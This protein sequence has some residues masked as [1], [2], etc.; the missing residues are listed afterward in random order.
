MLPHNLKGIRLPA[1]ERNLLKYRALEMVILLFYV[2]YLKSLVLDSIRATDRLRR[3]QNPRI[4]I[5]AKKAYEK[6]WAVLVTDGILTQGE[7]D[8]IRG[9]VDYRNTIAHEVQSLTCDVGDRRFAEC[10]MGSR[11]IKYDYKAVAKIKQYC[12]K[13]EHGFTSKCYIMSISLDGVAFAAAERTYERELRSLR[14]KITRQLTIRNKEICKLNAE[15]SAEVSGV[16]FEAHPSHPQSKATNGTLTK[17]GVETCYRLFDKNRSTV[18]VAHLMRI[19]YRAAVNRRRAWEKAG[20]QFR[21][22]GKP[23]QFR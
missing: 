18:A 14:Q 7:S 1:L 12:D 15:I 16:R 17:Q 9:I 13:I 8:E 21:C 22:S 2:E 11:A 6:A 3:P 5:N 23:S 20:G 19:S 10:Y 4:P